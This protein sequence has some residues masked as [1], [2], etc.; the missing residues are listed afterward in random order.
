MKIIVRRKEYGR[1]GS[2]L[3]FY[4]SSPVH[5]NNLLIRKEYKQDLV[6]H[7]NREKA[8]GGERKKARGSK[9]SSVN[10]EAVIF[11]SY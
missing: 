9:N 10:Q 1:Q 4:T 7:L 8:E 11:V 2:L 3:V 6:T 5:S